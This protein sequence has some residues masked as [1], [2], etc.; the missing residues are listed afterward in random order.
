MKIV[1]CVLGALVLAGCMDLPQPF[2]HQG[3]GSD[4]ARPVFDDAPEQTI[5]TPAAR[6]PTARL[7]EF[8]GLPGDGIKLLR[9][10]VKGALERRG[11]LVV[12]VD[13]D[14]V[15][16]P[17][18][19]LLEQGPDGAQLAVNWQVTSPQGED[20]GHVGQQGPVPPAA[21]K[22]DWGHLVHDIAEGGADGIVQI[23]Q[24]TFTKGRGD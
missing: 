4:L 10:A 14:V 16:V 18:L 24:T 19:Q 21:L 15:V 2:R 9:R 12:G 22:G 17:H 5:A 11:L 3:S 23:V 6:R 7:A 1:L 13:G 20:L 8:D